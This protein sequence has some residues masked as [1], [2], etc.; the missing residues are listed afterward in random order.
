MEDGVE[1]MC[2]EGD[3]FEP[4]EEEIE[5][6]EQE[7]PLMLANADRWDRFLAFMADAHAPWSAD[8]DAYREE[9]AVSYFNHSMRCSKDLLELKPTM[10][11]WVPHVS[12]FI[13]PRQ[14][15]ELG[16][17]SKRA[18]DACESF[19]AVTKHVI[20]KLTCRRRTRAADG[21][22]VSAIHKRRSAPRGAGGGRKEWKQTFGRGYLEQCFRRLCVREALLHGKEDE[23]Y[24]CREDW[25]LKW[26]GIKK[27]RVR[28]A[29]EVPPT[30]RATLEHES[31]DM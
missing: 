14:I 7:E 16:E 11:S 22:A 8:T 28:E 13:V 18:C 30:V 3:E 31:S 20:K 2:V 19:G 1:E 6:E 27:E 23:P 25:K 5:Q 21:S 17:P 29:R 10:Q 26:K 24:L 4:T 12:C 15:K 9:R